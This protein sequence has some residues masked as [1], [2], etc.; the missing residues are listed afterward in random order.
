M[1]TLVKLYGLGVRV[2]SSRFV[3]GLVLLLM[4]V[5]LGGVFW[6]SGQSKL[7]P[8]T[9]FSISDTTYY[10]FENDYASVPLPPHLAA[11]MATAAENILPIFLVLGLATRFSAAG[12]VIM[13]LVIQFFVYPEAWWAVHSLWLAMGLVLV[14]RGSGILGLDPLVAPLFEGRGKKV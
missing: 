5:A 4:R 1:A 14:V 11:V 6:R 9:W 13:T 12:L 8:D 2:A 10:L 3:E 7:V